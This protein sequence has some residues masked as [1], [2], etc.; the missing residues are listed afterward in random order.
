MDYDNSKYII[1]I[2]ITDLCIL[3]ILVLF[4]RILLELSYVYLISPGYTYMGLIMENTYGMY[5]ISWILSFLPIFSIA[6]LCGEVNFC[7]T[8]L[9][10]LYLICYIP[11]T[12]LFGYI[13][14]TFVPWFLLY[15]FFLFFYNRLFNTINAPSCFKLNKKGLNILMVFLV[16]V[17]IFI[18]GY[19]SHF[20]VNFSLYDVYARREEASSYQMP[21][22]VSYLFSGIKMI[23]PTLTV[24]ALSN[25]NKIFAFVYA[26]TLMVTF[27]IDGSKSVVVSLLAALIAYA[28][29]RRNK[30]VIKYMIVALSILLIFGLIEYIV[31]KSMVIDGL[32][33]RRAFFLPQRL[34]YYYY[35]FVSQNGPDYFRQGLI[36]HFG[37][38]SRYGMR[39]TNI[40]GEIYFG[41][42]NNSANNGLFSDAYYNLGYPGFFIMPALIIG[43]LKVLDSFSSGQR[44]E[45]RI[46]SIIAISISL[47]SSSF[48]TILLTHGGIF[49]AIIYLL[50]PRDIPESENQ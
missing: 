24:W 50:L 16:L 5:V 36:R 42:A 48:F 39:I 35:E 10:L 13:R 45:V 15:F 18:W 8:T 23:L 38:K 37:F 26:G 12:V 44:E 19:Y 1:R 40:I 43:F 2:N 28:I 3:A 20:R 14:A 49:L 41:S 4:Y 11:S 30:A 34:N 31:T 25:K 32:I 6:N 7:S 47:I 17:I 27:F 46:A 9:Y 29:I 33:I 21:T 22:L